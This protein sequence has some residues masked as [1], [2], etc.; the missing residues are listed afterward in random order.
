MFTDVKS[1]SF[2]GNIHNEDALAVGADFLAVIDGASGLN[3]VHLTNEPTDALWL[4][5]RV[6]Q[7]LEKA[8]ANPAADTFAVLRKIAKIVKTELDAF[9]YDRME[10][11]YPSACISLVRLR[12]EVL[13][14][15]ALGDCP[16]VL[17]STDGVRLVYDDAVTKRD[18]A[19]IRFM[20][21]TCREQ[22]I[23]MQQ[24]L[25]LAK[26]MLMKNRREMNQPGAYWVFE[27]TGAGIGQGVFLRENARRVKEVAVMSD[28]FWE[29]YALFGLA[30]SPAAFLNAM[31]AR[32]LDD[33]YRDLRRAQEKDAQLIR[34]PRFKCSDDTTAV[35]AAVQP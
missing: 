28:G 4:S 11:S 8:L 12:G 27:P 15:Y 23:S 2:A 10:Q 20:T 16:I 26:P 30:G 34:Y 22:G 29:Y 19:V 21:E 6:A 31:R 5:R 3:G 24:A 7:L 25:E 17:R 13:E 33:L 1:C 14:C 32:P 9:G 35:Y 18:E